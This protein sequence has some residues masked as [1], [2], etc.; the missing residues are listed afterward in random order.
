M[1]IFNE[2]TKLCLDENNN[3]SRRLNRMLGSIVDIIVSFDMGWS[4]HGNGKSYEGG[5]WSEIDESN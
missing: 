1:Y 5:C 3:N 4:N 2:S